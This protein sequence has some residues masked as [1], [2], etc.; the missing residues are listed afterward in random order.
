MLKKDIN[1]FLK[2][3]DVNDQNN[4]KFDPFEH[5]GDLASNL[6]SLTNL[7]DDMEKG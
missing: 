5:Y 1:N 4:F 6:G 2:K 3:Y 7:I